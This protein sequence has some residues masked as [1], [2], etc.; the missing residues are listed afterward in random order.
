MQLLEPGVSG[1]AVCMGS[2]GKVVCTAML[3]SPRSYRS[4]NSIH[5]LV[6][7]P[8]FCHHR[9][10]IL[11]TMYS[12]SRAFGDSI[13]RAFMRPY[14]HSNIRSFV[15]LNIR[16]FT[17]S[18]SRSAALQREARGLMA[19]PTTAAQHGVTVTT[20]GPAGIQRLSLC[21]CVCVC[22]CVRARACVRA[23]VCMLVCVRTFVCACACVHACT[24]LRAYVRAHVC[25][26]ACV[27]MR[28]CMPVRVCVWARMS[29]WLG[30][31]MIVY[32]M[33]HVIQYLHSH[34]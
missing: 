9:K 33:L 28:V 6:H 2:G 7:L 25:V 30:V 20:T 19:A 18:L 31:W 23:C 32:Y 10:N 12:F 11:R 29:A 4:V 26:C 22:V 24:R 17:H 21:V 1:K 3:P 16:A 27:C 14:N 8:F 34:S 5:S 15:H 13:I